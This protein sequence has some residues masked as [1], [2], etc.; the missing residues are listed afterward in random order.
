MVQKIA[1]IV[2]GLGLLLTGCT[3]GTVQVT[4]T[5]SPTGLLTPYHTLTPSPQK[6]T[7]TI[8]VTIPVTPAP[9]PTPYLYTVKDDDTMLGIA[10]Q[11]GVKLED[12]QA[13]N[14]K[15][16]PHFMGKGLQL[17]IPLGG[18]IPQVVPTPTAI[19]VDAGQPFCY[20]TGDGGAWCIVAV[21]ND[22]KVSLENLSVWV[23]LYNFQGENIISQVAYAPLNILRPGNTMPLMVYF[24]PPL[25]VEFQAQA[26]VLSALSVAV[27]D[28]RYIDTQVKVDAVEISPDGGTAEVSGKVVVAENAQSMSQLW[29]LAVAYDAEGNIVGARKW[30]SAGE[31]EFDF[32]VFSLAGAIDHVEVLS[33]ARP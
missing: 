32:S 21:R 12:L 30:K 31:T 10:F 6:P 28:Q 9:T 7:A 1:I 26:E 16:D 29:L 14:P 5:D 11:F 24:A 22:Q 19:P 15:V 20:H 25:P 33:E 27:D 8:Q 18:E 3:Q 4:Y 2:V 17:V 13:A 23:G